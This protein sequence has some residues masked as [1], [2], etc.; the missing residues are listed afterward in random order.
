MTRSAEGASCYSFVENHWFCGSYWSD[1][2][3]ELTD[4]TV[5][6][7]WITVVSVLLGLAL[8]VPLALLA[9]K[10]PTVESV[11]VGSTTIIYT[12]LLYTSPSP[13]DS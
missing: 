6:H 3:Q 9:R 2:R 7:V 13:R 4:A 12:C 8:A 11:V 1:Y 10:S 5:Q